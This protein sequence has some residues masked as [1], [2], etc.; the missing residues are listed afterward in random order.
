MKLIKT[1]DEGVAKELIASKFTL[2]NKDAS[3]MYTFLNNGHKTFSEEEKK[4]MAF[5]NMMTMERKD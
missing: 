3:G 4:K 1:R 2:V 5:T